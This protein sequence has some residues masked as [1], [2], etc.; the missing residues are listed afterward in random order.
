MD[1]FARDASFFALRFARSSAV[2]SLAPVYESATRTLPPLQPN[3]QISIAIA[4]TWFHAVVSVTSLSDATLNAWL[5]PTP[6]GVR[7]AVLAI[8]LPPTIAMTVWRATGMP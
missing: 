8:E 7:E 4:N 6:P 3:A 5:T 2:L 1:Q